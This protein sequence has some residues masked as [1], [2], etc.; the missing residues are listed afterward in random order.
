HNRFQKELIKPGDRVLAF[1]SS[2]PH[3][4][5]Y[6]LINRLITEGKMN[7]DKWINDL[8]CPHRN[9]YSEL[10]RIWNAHPIVQIKGLCH[11]TG[12]GLIDNPPRILPD[13]VRIEWDTWKLPSVFEEIK[14]VSGLDMDQMYRTFNCGLGM[15]MVVPDNKNMIDQL[16]QMFPDLLSVGIVRDK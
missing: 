2:G 7:P 13:E 15:L 1:P 9:Y 6:S 4:N 8:T 3:T 12:G 16:Y 11:I 14:R 10:T 5:G